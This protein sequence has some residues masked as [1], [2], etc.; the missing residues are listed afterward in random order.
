MKQSEKVIT[1]LLLMALGVMF[2]ILKD[3]FI[4]ILMTVVGASLIVLGIV[5]II[6]GNYPQA[7][8]KIVSGLLLVI[9]G[10]VIVEA[11]LYVLSGILL[12]FGLLLLYDK[13]R[14]RICR[15]TLWQ[16]VLEY[17]TPVICIVIGVLLLF[18]RE[19]FVNLVFI[20]S[21]ILLALEGG[22]VLLSAF[23]DE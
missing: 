6:G 4:G 19:S 12:I 15:S 10:W 16:T 18:H 20:V 17:A 5:D 8:V 7:I 2:I 21:G 9:C 3:N 23:A 14:N 11:V 1:A 13:I 22:V